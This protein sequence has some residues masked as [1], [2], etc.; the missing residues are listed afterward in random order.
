MTEAAPANPGPRGVS[1]QGGRTD[2]TAGLARPTGLRAVSG[3]GHV[4]L[5][6]DP[7]PGAAGY[8]VY[9]AAGEP[10]EP[11]LKNVR[12]KTMMPRTPT[13]IRV[14]AAATSL[15]PPAVLLF[16]AALGQASPPGDDAPP[17]TGRL[18]LTAFRSR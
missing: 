9:R 12:I 14:R 3:R 18:E 2:V 7:V 1:G 6:W 13:L 15:R 11:L 17:P 16:D 10:Y 5:D 8:L 4:T